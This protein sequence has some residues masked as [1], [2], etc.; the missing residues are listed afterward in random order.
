MGDDKDII[1]GVDLGEEPLAE[2][3]PTAEVRVPTREEM[4]ASKASES[5]LEVTFRELGW[6]FE[7]R[8][9]HSLRD[10]DE[11]STQARLLREHP[12]FK[13]ENDETVHLTPVQAMSIAWVRACLV[14]P[15]L[16]T[17]DVVAISQEH[18]YVVSMLAEYAIGHNGADGQAVE[19][20]KKG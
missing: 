5:I 7:L 9:L 18:G 17:A 20:A 6:R 10:L 1:E 16:S 19:T 2:L 15:Q 14:E 11:V 3:R 4:L 8:R 12:G 13:L